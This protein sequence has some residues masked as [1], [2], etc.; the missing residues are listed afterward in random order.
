MVWG[1]TLLN[2]YINPEKISDMCW[3]D[4]NKKIPDSRSI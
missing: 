1:F 3:P 2:K 4:L